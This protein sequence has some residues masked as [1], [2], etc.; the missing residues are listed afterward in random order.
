MPTSRR[1]SPLFSPPL[2]GWLLT[3]CLLWAGIAV[4]A[5]LETTAPIKKF[6]LPTFTPEGYRG[7]LLHGEEARLINTDRIE[8]RDMQLTYFDGTSAEKVETVF[9]STFAIF[10]PSSQLAEGEK[11][12][13]IVRDDAEMSGERWTYRHREKKVV[14]D[15]NVRVMFRAQLKDVLK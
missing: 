11:G 14:I 12:V 9:I 7:I 5:P 6:T 2:A 4:A 8:I 13:R 3:A 15:G 1:Q 10:H